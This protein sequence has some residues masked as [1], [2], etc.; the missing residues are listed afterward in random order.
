MA[1]QRLIAS[2]RSLSQD[3]FRR[4][5][6]DDIRG[7]SSGDVREAL[8]SSGLVDRWVETLESALVSVEGQL[9]ANDA[10]WGAKEA[11]FESSG[12]HVALLAEKAKNDRWRAGALRFRT[13]VQQTLIEA[14]RLAA[15]QEKESSEVDRLTRERDRAMA[16][17]F[18]LEDAIRSH[19]Q[20]FPTEDEPSDN[21]LDLWKKVDAR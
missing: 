7:R 19:K 11:E 17:A 6:D 9:A 3:D 18:M 5:V 15:A 2:L 21:D 1:D 12:D 13:G 14:R 20:N 4:V 10:D 16:R 8:R